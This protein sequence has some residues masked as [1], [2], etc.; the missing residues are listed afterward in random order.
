MTQ[1]NNGT[2]EIALGEHVQDEVTG[3]EGVVTGRVDYIAGCR[4]YL[5]QPPVDERDKW[6]E[7]R[8]FDE[9]RLLE[10]KLHP[11]TEGKPSTGSDLEAP[12]K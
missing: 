5:V 3:F 11:P 10:D 6:V 12:R 1:L 2:F 8:W 7:A 4:Q 9:D